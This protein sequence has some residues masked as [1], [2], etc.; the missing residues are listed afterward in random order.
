MMNRCIVKLCRVK[1][2]PFFSVAD[3]VSLSLAFRNDKHEVAFRND[4][5][6]VHGDASILVCFPSF[7]KTLTYKIYSQSFMRKKRP[8]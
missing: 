4:E 6:E 5:H 2:G 3:K 8:T 1:Y 7:Q